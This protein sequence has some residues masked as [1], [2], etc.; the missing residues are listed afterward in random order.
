M[1]IATN[2]WEVET[3]KKKLEKIVKMERA[4]V[5]F[6]RTTKVR[7]PL[8]R[9]NRWGRQSPP[10]I[11]AEMEAKTFSQKNAL[12]F[13]LTPT[14]LYF[15]IFLRSCTKTRKNLIITYV[16]QTRKGLTFDTLC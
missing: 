11:M 8:A 2:N 12:D 13:Y 1:S 6:S 9:R 4:T 5:L 7:L 16:L 14:P 3:Y 15:Q 10:L